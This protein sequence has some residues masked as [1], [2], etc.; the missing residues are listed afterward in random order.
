MALGE[1]RHRAYLERVALPHPTWEKRRCHAI[2]VGKGGGRRTAVCF[3]GGACTGANGERYAAAHLRTV[4]HVRVVM[5][6]PNVFSISAM[7]TGP[8]GLGR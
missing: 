5:P 1:Q 4:S 3:V 7:K 8:R 6:R 2:R